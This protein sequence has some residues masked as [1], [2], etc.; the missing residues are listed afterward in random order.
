MAPEKQGSVYDLR[1]KKKWL[2]SCDEAE[3]RQIGQAAYKAFNVVNGACGL[4]WVL[5]I[6]LSYAFHFSVQLPVFLVC[7]LWLLL[8]VTYTL[9]CIRLGRRK[10]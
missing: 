9:E 5:L 10:G 3:Q 7:L 2:E 6:L 4:L 1:F 8:S